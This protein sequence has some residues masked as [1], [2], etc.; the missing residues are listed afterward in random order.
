MNAIKIALSTVQKAILHMLF[1][2]KKN[3]FMPKN[4]AN[5]VVMGIMDD[6]VI[7]FAIMRTYE[8]VR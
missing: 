5:Q 1:S 8:S 3:Q 4:V 7:Q 6:G 2:D